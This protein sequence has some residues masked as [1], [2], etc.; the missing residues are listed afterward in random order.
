MEVTLL[1]TAAEGS[2]TD[3]NIER[4]VVVSQDKTMMIWT[5]GANEG[6]HNRT[7]PE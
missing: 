4:I 1:K 2:S 7:E 6:E 5:S 3:H